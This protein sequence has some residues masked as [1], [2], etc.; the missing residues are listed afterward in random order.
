VHKLKLGRNVLQKGRMQDLV[1]QKISLAES[2]TFITCD[3]HYI[4]IQIVL[5][6]LDIRFERA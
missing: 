4:R 5:K 3:I 2:K 6:R 1:P